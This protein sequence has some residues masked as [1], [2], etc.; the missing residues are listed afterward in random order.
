MDSRTH[1]KGIEVSIIEK[2]VAMLQNKYPNFEY[3]T[4]YLAALGIDNDI[5]YHNVRDMLTHFHKALTAKLSLREREDQILHAE[6]HLRRALVEPFELGAREEF[7][8]AQELYEKFRNLI[9]ISKKK[10]KLFIK[11]PAEKKIKD[12]S[13]LFICTW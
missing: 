4:Y 1:I 11:A 2:I 9:K 10:E 5:G 6:E 8:R 7:K 12:T 13:W 3:G